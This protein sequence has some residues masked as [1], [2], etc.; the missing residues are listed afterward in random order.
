MTDFI[1][2]ARCG[3]PMPAFKT[4]QLRG[5]LGILIVLALWQVSVWII[6]LPA[7]FY[8]GPADVASAFVDLLRKGI[9]PA[10]IADSAFRYATGVTTGLTLGVGFGLL[11]GL[12]RFWSRLLGPIINFF[13]AIVE[14]AW[15]P[16]LVI[17]IVQNSA[18]RTED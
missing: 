8:P 11:I 5:M 9:L 15:I 10:Y 16:L 4:S 1:A 18:L 2:T 14:V 6:A 3:L 17:W 12:S 7:Y 13:Y